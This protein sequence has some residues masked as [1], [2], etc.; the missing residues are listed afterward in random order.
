M[1]VEKKIFV[2]LSQLAAT[3]FKSLAQLNRRVRTILDEAHMEVVSV[4]GNNPSLKVT[5]P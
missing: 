3:R 1:M 5:L 4:G 2:L